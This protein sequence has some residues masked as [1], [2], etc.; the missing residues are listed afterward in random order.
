MADE[1]NVEGLDEL[2]QAL[3]QLPAKLQGKAMQATLAKAAKPIVAA[4]RQLAPVKTGTLRRAI[5]SFRD[6]QSTPTR[7][8]R[9]ISVRRGKKAQKSNRDAYY[10]KFI[11]FGHGPIK[12]KSGKSLGNVEDG[13]FGTEVKAVPPRPFL[14]PAFEANKLKALDIVRTELQGQINKAAQKAY[15]RSISRLASALRKT[16]I[17]I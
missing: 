17:G 6:R 1:I 8:G 2:R 11:E 3:Q 16:T 5:Y 13:F 14:R 12:S 9:L 10:W 7:E 15:Q 4:A